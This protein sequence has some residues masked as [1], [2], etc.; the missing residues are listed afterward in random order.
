MNVKQ[1]YRYV[2]VFLLSVFVFT[3]CGSD[4][5]GGEF[6]SPPDTTKP[7]ITLN[8]VNPLELTK[9][10]AYTEAGAT[11]TDD[12]DGVITVT[13]SGTV[14]VNVVNSY[15][16]T[17]KAKD[18]AGNEAVVTRIVKVVLPPD[19][20]KPVITLN[21]ANPLE[22]TKGSTYTELGATA[23][24]DRDGVVNV[25]ISGTVDVNSVNSYTITY[26]AKDKAGNE[27]VA[28]RTVKV[29]LPPDTTKPVITLNGANLLE[30][31]KGATYTELGATAIDDRDGNLS[32]IISGVV[33]SSIVGTYTITYS[34]TDKAGNKAVIKR[35]VEVV[36]EDDT[37]LPIITLN[38]D[39]NI[40]ITKG[41]I[42]NEL[43]ATAIDDRDGNLSVTIS[44]VVD[45]ST[46]GTYTITYSATDNA[47]NKA[48][49]MRVIK[50]IESI[51]TKGY[52]IDS[53]LAGVTYS[54]DGSEGLTDDEGMFECIA[55][56][57]TFKI[58][59]LTLGTLTSFTSDGK[60]YPQDLLGLSRTNFTD[61]RL[62]LLARLLQS[63]DDDGVI[64]EKITITQ[65]VRDGITDVQNFKDM[66]QS[67]VQSL[68]SG[69][70]K[71]FVKECEALKHLGASVSCGSDGGYM[72]SSSGGSLSGGGTTTST[73]KTTITGYAE[74]DPMPNAKIRVTDASDNLVVETTADA[75]G[76][77]TLSAN[78]VNGKTYTLESK[79]KLGDRNIT[80]HSIFKFSADTV[81]NA[82]PITELKYQ[83]VQSGKTLE[84]AEALIRDYFSVVSGEKL[85]RNRFDVEG[86][87]ALGMVDLAK[88]YDG[89]LPVDAIEK[90]KED[91]IRN[92]EL[93]VEE[94]DY[95]YRDLLRLKLSLSASSSSLKV[96]ESVTVTLT[97]A[98]DLNKNYQFE[99][100]GVPNDN[101]DST[102]T[103]TFTLQEPQDIFI[104][105]NLYLKDENNSSKN[106]LIETQS[107]KVNFY[108][109]EEPQ[110]I[111]ITGDDIN[112]SIGSDVKINIPAN[113]LSAGQQISYSEVTTNSSDYLKVFNLEPSGT[114]FSEPM[115]IRI[116]Y[117]PS[118]VY[119][120]RL[121]SI[122]RVSADGTEEILK[123]KRIDYANSE[124]IFE[125]EHFSEF[126][127]ERH[128]FLNLTQSSFGVWEDKKGFGT[129][130]INGIDVSWY[131]PYHYL[132]ESLNSYCQD[133]GINNTK[134][135]NWLSFFQN[136]NNAEE[137]EDAYHTF[138]NK[139]ANYKI[140]TGDYFIWSY[141]RHIEAYDD[142]G[143]LYIP[144]TD[145][146][147]QNS[148]ELLF[149]GKLEGDRATNI[150]SY[151]SNIEV[152][153][154]DIDKFNKGQTKLMSGEVKS[155]KKINKKIL[156]KLLAKELVKT[157]QIPTKIFTKFLDISAD[158][159][160]KTITYSQ[161]S[162]QDSDDMVTHIFYG[163]TSSSSKHE[164]KLDE[165]G[166]LLKNNLRLS[167]IETDVI[168]KQIYPYHRDGLITYFN[169]EKDD[170]AKENR[171]SFLSTY[172]LEIKLA[173]DFA[174][175]KIE[176]DDFKKSFTD[177]GALVAL[178]ILQYADKVKASDLISEKQAKLN[179]IEEFLLHRTNKL[180][181][182]S[183]QKSE[184]T[185]SEIVTIPVLDSF[186]KF[187]EQIK[188]N[189]PESKWDSIEVKK[190]S[191]DIDKY[192]IESEASTDT[193]QMT[194][195]M[196]SFAG[197]SIF[198][199]SNI[200]KDGFTLANEKYSQ[201]LASIF[202][203]FDSS[204][205][206]D[207]F[208]VVKANIL[209]KLN[210][211]DRVVSK[212]YQ[213]ITYVDSDDELESE[214][215]YGKLTSAIRDAVS[216]E[217]IADAR[218]TLL[219]IDITN[220]TDENGNYSFSKLPPNTYDVRVAK[221]G[222]KT[223]TIYDVTL[224]DGEV[225]NIEVL[226]AIDDAHAE[227]NGTA[228]ITLKDA[229]NGNVVTNGYVKVR[230]GQNN[231]TGEVVQEVVN[232]DGN[233]NVH[234]SLYPNTYTVEIGANGYSKAYNTVT[235][236]GDVNGAYEFSITPVL[237]AD[238]VRAVLTWGE[239]PSDLDSHLV[240]KTDGSQ[241]Y[242]IFY[243][244]QRPSN[245]DANLDTDDTSSY[246][247]ETVTINNVNHASVYT[248]YVYNYSGGAGSV[249]P[250]SG[251]KLEVY[252]GDQSRTF[253]VPNEEGQYWK[254]FEIVN[255]EIVPCTTD[256]VKD[257]TSTLIRKI[258]RK[259]ALF[260][261][262][263]SK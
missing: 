220:N 80:L 47:G 178:Q 104:S 187:L 112:V 250:N 54:C 125:T 81:I 204:E 203:D 9:G 159:L 156:G 101:N 107:V 163:T 206:Q 173:Y 151:I 22:L 233:Q 113:A 23:T 212:E 44:G 24:D 30:L 32:V 210:G 161:Y 196:T 117:D 21:G 254:V 170:K 55:P 211:V 262:L 138:F 33:D 167:N 197:T 201:N 39:N 150:L 110:N 85:E 129:T 100:V 67:D 222:Y 202:D 147:L 246:G 38:G 237:S 82:N 7:V 6:V 72:V 143:N 57:V 16:V 216:S 20:T 35:V 123:V 106:I 48:T 223:V 140:F 225:K 63:L 121:L 84:D 228:T 172:Y 145:T 11:A 108:K 75:N 1:F 62:K 238:Q 17:Y 144:V 2:F 249:L 209:I 135:K 14:D 255:G 241:D 116:K 240:K 142:N 133:N 83:L 124:L 99:W 229:I 95:A 120:P 130:S 40:T 132:V 60:V 236:L 51:K 168:L 171:Q 92:S 213:F 141:I 193:T 174:Y 3:G 234:I 5:G 74:D 122:K 226:L 214:P 118:Q 217:P 25:T 260:S 134:C 28:T 43:G 128:G 97:G 29:V 114:V 157:A 247:P 56:P 166:Y 137:I 19:T 90:I 41:D 146:I 244:N 26:R 91:I 205:L 105:L 59:N 192:T 77:Y 36:L 219:P 259:S 34:A 109:V 195:K 177:R 65:G 78:F 200:T 139:G 184:T 261:N 175:N 66:S 252:F 188:I 115:E 256:C 253:Y 42:Y 86:S 45:S 52:L 149:N 154:F 31:T 245:A 180:Q 103:K 58:G 87:L 119:D 127:I 131:T 152:L 232:S 53:P 179:K 4:N 208:V 235:I 64:A 61:S 251:A 18:K 148:T 27:A 194:F 169:D 158:I 10:T 263:P 239:T 136:K 207:S 176:R 155:L 164:F 224:A 227:N 191:L 111:D 76:K 69:L 181:K 88:L 93:A 94:Q 189:I 186:D 160:T 199:K 70:G 50:V 71:T 79:G 182:R 183:F 102:L 37:T 257:D 96:G 8:G 73:Q 15:T 230:E 165:E 258:D 162:A 185:E 12:R 126:W 49:V 190:V 13:I 153:K 98:E 221:E 198:S 231:K 248:Y 242:H 46:V 243:N 68:V 215:E 218:V 89:L